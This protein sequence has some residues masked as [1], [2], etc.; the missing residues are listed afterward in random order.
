M[1]RSRRA[2]LPAVVVLLLCVFPGYAQEPLRLN[3]GNAVDM[4]IRNNLNLEMARINL[5]M[6]RRRSDLVWNEFLPTVGVTGTLARGNRATTT[7]PGMIVA[8]LGAT[9]IP[10]EHPLFGS[11]VVFPN[12]DIFLREIPS[13]TLPQWNVMG[14][15]NAEL[16]FS[17]ALLEGI[18]VV[19]NEYAEGLL[20]FD[21]ARL[22]MEQGV[23][24]MYNNILLLQANLALLEESY[25]N[26]RRQ[27]DMAEASFNAGLAPR[28][29]W[30]QAQVAVE[31]TRPAVRDLENTLGNVLG[32]FAL[33]LGLPH[34]TPLELEPVSFDVSVIPWDVAE[35]ISRAA[36]GKPDILELQA[37][38]ITLQSQRQALRLQLY[39]PFLRFGWTLSSM[40]DPQTDP[41]GENWFDRDHWEAGGNFS[42]TLG[43]NF[44]GL[45]PFTRE[46]QQ[47]RNM[48]SAL[49]IQNIR[50]AQTIRETELEIFTMINTLERIRA[51]VEVQRATV[52]LA[53]ESFRLT[54]EAFRA[55]LQE[56][57]A[58]QNA[59]LALD[60]ARLRVLTEQFTY[61]NYLIDLEY[62]LGI[63]FGTISGDGNM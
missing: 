63:P 54:E 47:I 14:A 26:A 52:Y 24:K 41:F 2:F 61:L 33:I 49:Q 4:A 19:R 46:G 35:M 10:V 20:S 17:F 39:T 40:F 60:Q 8:P 18:R 30:L 51:N 25:L 12:P 3:P 34:D 57:Q 15:L 37:G 28:L 44:N 32:N 13:V 22:Q 56:F 45:F 9:T 43:M 1:N 11:G 36:A 42:I 5:D 27:A 16:V 53:E 62:S 50:L 21:R 23:R 6:Q 55:G 59:A 29:T 58:V 7:Q 48:N 38:I 31:N